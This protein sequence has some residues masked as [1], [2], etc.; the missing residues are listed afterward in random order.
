MI[1]EKTTHPA[2]APL[3][4]LFGYALGEGATALTI[5]S[6]AGFGMLFYT[7]I[8]GM[9]AAM[10]GLVLAITLLL[11]AVID[12]VMGFIS[13]NTRTRFGRRHIYMLTGGIGLALAYLLL[14]RVP[15]LFNG[16][17]A[18][19]ICILTMNMLL[20]T[21]STIYGVPYAALGFE[22]CTEYADRS[23]LQG[24]RLFLAQIINL[25]ASGLA[26][27]VFFKDGVAADGTR[28]DGGLIKANY[29]H[30][31][32]TMGLLALTLVI[33]CTW[34]TRKYA[35]DN[36]HDVVER[37]GIKDF[38]HTFG[39]VLSNRL[40][41]PVLGFFCIAQLG[42]FLTGVMNTF[43]MI[44]FMKLSSSAK[45][46]VMGLSIFTF[47]LASLGLA[48]LVKRFDKK[49]IGFLGIAL[50][51]A[52]GLILFAVFRS[53]LATPE[54]TVSLAGRT[55]SVGVVVFAFFT[56]TFQAG[57]GLTVPLTSSMI[58]DVS[59]IDF[60][61]N[62]H[63]RDGSYA[64]ILS[65]FVKLSVALG[66]LV[67]GGLLQWVGIISG[68]EVQ[69]PEAIRKLS[70]AAF[71]CGP[72]LLIPALIVLCFYPVNRAFMARLHAGGFNQ[73]EPK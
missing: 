17:L 20:R 6:V 28:L 30:M 33:L 29:M 18:L 42:M 55:I 65:F 63:V 58:A 67:V 62:G 56:M 1:K 72:A 49:T 61:K 4:T 23:R 8:L 3:R 15:L 71:L 47:A 38:F 54:M 73:E 52:S 59:E 24:I 7:Q 46:W 19:F 12:P 5:W 57:W 27:V 10:A 69:T 70:S 13:D 60:R 40:A 39:Q 22:V 53:G 2:P 45:S 44:Y 9:N 64:A 16:P 41:W 66:D 11:D 35:V 25:F 50:S 21:A 14:W 31:S 34:V 43:N 48:R 36:R 51:A 68:C 37:K 32:L 26:W